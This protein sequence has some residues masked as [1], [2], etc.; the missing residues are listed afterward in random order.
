MAWQFRAG[1]GDN[2]CVFGLAL[3][4]YMAPIETVFTTIDPKPNLKPQL[5]TTEP[6][7]DLLWNTHLYS[8]H[9]GLSCYSNHIT[10][11]NSQFKAL[12]IAHHLPNYTSSRYIQEEHTKMGNPTSR[13]HHLAQRYIKRKTP[14][15]TLFNT[16]QHTRTQFKETN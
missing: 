11:K 1:L 16:I 14:A 13:I 5:Q 2:A 4:V 3:G 10:W 8:S 15:S 6:W 7:S 12:K 9:A